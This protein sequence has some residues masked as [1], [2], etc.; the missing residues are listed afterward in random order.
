[1]LHV[2]KLYCKVM[3]TYSYTLTYQWAIYQSAKT[4]AFIPIL[5]VIIFFKRRTVSG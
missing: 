1:M 2:Y 3:I 4:K 5:A